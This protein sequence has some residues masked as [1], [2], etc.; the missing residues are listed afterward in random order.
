MEFLLEH[1]KIDVDRKT[2]EGH[3]PLRLAIGRK[4]TA[5]IQVLMLAGADDEHGSSSSSDSEE[6][7]DMNTSEVRKG[8]TKAF[9]L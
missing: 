1:P 9:F 6:E 8:R 5:M 2:Y 7:E 4:L 3:T